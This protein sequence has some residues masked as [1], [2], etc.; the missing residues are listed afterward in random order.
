MSKNH[1]VIYTFDGLRYL[2]NYAVGMPHSLK[3]AYNNQQLNC[4]NCIKI[5]KGQAERSGYKFGVA[6]K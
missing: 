5:L 3:I 4:K 1:A 6:K 2:C